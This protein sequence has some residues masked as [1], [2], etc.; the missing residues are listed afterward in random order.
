VDVDR[1]PLTRLDERSGIDRSVAADHDV[2]RTSD[3]DRAANECARRKIDGRIAPDMKHVSA[4]KNVDA[5]AEEDEPPLS[6][7]ASSRLVH[8]EMHVVEDVAI[9]LERD[10]G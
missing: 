7:R 10:I 6:R 8:E 3:L 1:R 2:V 9:D 4:W 5:R